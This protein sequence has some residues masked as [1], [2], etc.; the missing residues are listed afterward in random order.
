[1]TNGNQKTKRRINIRRPY[2]N[3][4]RKRA[5]LELDIEPDAIDINT[6]YD[7]PD[8]KGEY[9]SSCHIVK[10]HIKRLENNSI[11]GQIFDNNVPITDNNYIFDVINAYNLYINMLNLEKNI[12]TGELI[13]Q[14]DKLQDIYLHVY[15]N[16]SKKFGTIEDDTYI[17]YIKI[18]NTIVNSCFIDMYYNNN[19]NININR[20]NIKH[21]KQNKLIFELSSISTTPAYL[22]RGFTKVLVMYIIDRILRVYETRYETMKNISIKL[23][24][25]TSQFPFTDFYARL[26]FYLRL[27]FIPDQYEISEIMYINRDGEVDTITLNDFYAIMNELYQKN[28]TTFGIKHIKKAFPLIYPSNDYVTLEY[29]LEKAFLNRQIIRNIYSMI[30]NKRYKELSSLYTRSLFARN[31][32]VVTHSS[33][34][35]DKDDTRFF[36]SNSVPAN[37]E[38]VII[39]SPGYYKYLSYLYSEHN[40]IKKYLNI[41]P[42]DVLQSLFPPFKSVL[43]YNKIPSVNH[44]A[45]SNFAGINFLES[46]SGGVVLEVCDLVSKNPSYIQIH[47]YKAGDI[48]P[49]LLLAIK[50][51]LKSD[52]MIYPVSGLYDIGSNDFK[53][54]DIYKNPGDRNEWMNTIKYI[55]EH[56]M[57]SEEIATNYQKILSRKTLIYDGMQRMDKDNYINTDISKIVQMN[58]S[59]YINDILRDKNELLENKVNEP[60]RF[61]FTSCG[62]IIEPVVHQNYM[63][64]NSNNSTNANTI[65]SNVSVENK[66]EMIN[67]YLQNIINY[68]ISKRIV[69]TSDCTI[70][71]NNIINNYEQTLNNVGNVL[72]NSILPY[73]KASPQAGGRKMVLR[74]T[75]RKKRKTTNKK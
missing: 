66:Y 58:I 2:N 40:L 3:T 29:P 38:I 73:L 55:N 43:Q 70:S 1:M 13:P 21:N 4:T 11:T 36:L 9:V 60:I 28:P 71:I 74:K 42:I 15:N 44:S 37:C 34:E 48:Y 75:M 57:Q 46:T 35:L 23:Q 61:Y 49:D 62:D 17:A 22:K 72:Y 39:N 41:F 8:I 54:L 18:H 20:K 32:V 14:V 27:G 16:V 59:S 69:S 52:D 12:D 64:Y 68:K 6:N 53:V 24:V 47:S 5:K 26:L 30:L 7:S 45:Y 51:G 33:Y 63:N 67:L 56:K 25:S 31:L 19:N 10:I 65:N 50:A